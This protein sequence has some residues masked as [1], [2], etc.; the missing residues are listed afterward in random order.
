MDTKA[1]EKDLVARFPTLEPDAAEDSGLLHV[2]L[3]HLYRFTQKEIQNGKWDNVKA[4]F[5][6]LDE[7]LATGDLKMEN[8]IRV[9]FL[10]YFEFGNYED[11]IRELLGPTLRGLYEDQMKYMEELARMAAEQPPPADPAKPAG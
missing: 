1:F 10:E 8:A 6:F 2:A 9:S 5:R 4:V 7:W 11:R 3:G